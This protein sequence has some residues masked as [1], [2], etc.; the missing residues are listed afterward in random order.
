[1]VR[2]LNLCDVKYVARVIMHAIMYMSRIVY[3]L[4]PARLWL[5]WPRTGFRPLLGLR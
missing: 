2:E 4:R 1:M 3:R 5:A